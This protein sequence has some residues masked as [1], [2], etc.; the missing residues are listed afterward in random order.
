MT[1]TSALAASSSALA[2]ATGSPSDSR[3]AIA[4]GPSSIA[5]SASM[6]ADSAARFVSVFLTTEKRAPCSISFV[7][8]SSSSVTVRPR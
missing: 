5:S 4:V 7:R 2:T 1:S 8:S 6:P 3:N